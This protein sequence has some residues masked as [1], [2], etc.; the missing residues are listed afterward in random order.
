MNIKFLN[1][2]TFFSSVDKNALENILTITEKRP[3]D[4][5]VE[6]SS[7]CALS[8][9]FCPNKDYR[10]PKEVMDLPRFKKICDEYHKMGGGAF[11]LS[12]MQSDVFS[13]SLLM[14]RVKLLGEYK[15]SFWVYTTTTLIGAKKLSNEDLLNFLKVFSFI[16]ISFGGPDKESYQAMFGVN[17]FDIVCEQIER[18][19][20]MI[21]LNRLSVQLK[22]AIRTSNKDEY[23]ESTIY[24]KLRINK[25]IREINIRDSFFSWGGL[26][27]QEH[28]P[29]GAKIDECNNDQKKVNC[30]VPSAQLSIS[31]NGDV[32]GC[33]CVDWNSE[34]VIGNVFSES[35]ELV[36]RG[37]RAKKFR[38][39]FA[40]NAIPE[41][42]K[43]CSLY[44]PIDLGF[45]VKRLR[46][47][48]TTDGLY[49]VV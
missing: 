39:A 16:E 6:V 33:G 38:N 2:F 49:Y 13:D 46:K 45:G 14:D 12:S 15:K 40:D 5:N 23:L 42:C 34:Y 3:L 31:A 36:W 44:H 21:K 4:I 35:I 27:R 29:I 26:V 22:L 25:Q 7:Y 37:E 11:G 43:K 20:S 32:V 24:K 48:K 30:V 47:F 28:L 19:T 41:M 9:S 8:C 10:H 1:K 18:I 17:A